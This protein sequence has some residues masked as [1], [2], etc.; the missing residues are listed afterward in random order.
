MRTLRSRIAREFGPRET[1]EID[2]RAS[3]ATNENL[4]G[5]GWARRVPGMEHAA[6]L[7]ECSALRLVRE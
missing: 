6:I 4:Q 3:K 1:R 5:E 2:L 7:P